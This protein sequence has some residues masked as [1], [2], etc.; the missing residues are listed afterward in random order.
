MFHSSQTEPGGDNFAQ[1]VNPELD[2]LLEAARREIDEPARMKIWQQVHAVLWRDQ[3]Y[4]FLIRGK[5]LDFISKRLHNVT[6]VKAGLNRGGLWRMPMEW[7]V[8][9][10]EQ[11]YVQ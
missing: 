11:R 4:T 1:Y 3:P 8:P 2:V 10:S 9:T 7:Y 5:R 6:V